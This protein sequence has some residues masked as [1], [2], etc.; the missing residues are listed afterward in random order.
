M[1]IGIFVGLATLDLVYDVDEFPAPNT[2]IAARTQ[3]IF[4]GG[5]ATN[6][7]ITFA[8]LGGQ[9][10]LVTALGRH[11][12]TQ[13]VRQEL[14][15]FSIR[16]ID[17]YPE[18]DD[19]PALSS[20]AVDRRGRRNVVSANAERIVAPPAQ[21]DLDLCRQASIVL[22]DGHS[23][24]ACQAWA[25]AAH[26][27]GLPVVLDGGSWKDGTE[28]LLGQLHTAIC[29]ADFLPPNCSGQQDLVRFIKNRGVANFA[30]THGAAPVDYFF[31]ND[32]GTVSVPRLP[33]IDTMGAGDIFHGAYCFFA[34]SGMDFVPAL[35]AA[36]KVAS[37]SCRF[38]GTRAWMKNTGR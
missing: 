18:F 34:S 1:P 16:L 38:A 37:E 8:H 11:P 19:L 14:Q 20:V 3:Q 25:E 17:L 6:A 12:L 9:A 4:V 23:M 33:V 5:P 10:T 30:I 35:E 15:R 21:V 36:A 32:A 7:A 28:A 29:S 2:K 26:T 13:L 31:G 22:V 27:C 24:Q